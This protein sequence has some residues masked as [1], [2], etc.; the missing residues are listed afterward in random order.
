MLPLQFALVLL[1]FL[2]AAIVVWRYREQII[3][4]VHL[5]N[6]K[7]AADR[8]YSS[9]HGITKNIAYGN[10]ERE[11]LDI[12]QP[13]GNGPMPV[14][15]WVHG[16]SWTSGDKELYA[17]VAQRFMPENFVVV[18]PNYTIELPSAP[19]G[20]PL[21]FQQFREIAQAFVWTREN[22]SQFKGDPN[23]IVL[24]GHS[25]GAHLT[26]MVMLDPQYLAA[27]NHSAH[28]ICGWYGFAGP[29]SIP[30]QLEYELNVHKNDAGLLFEVFGGKENFVCG[31]P[32]TFVRGDTP[33]VFM[34]H[35][36]ADETV[37]VAIGENFQNALQKASAPSTLSIYRGAGHAG[38]LFDALAQ[39]KPRLVQD[40]VTFAK[41]CPPVRNE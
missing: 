20:E 2:L 40:M 21:V 9:Y 28:E 17:T 10:A 33:P 23:R 15:I 11:K 19:G 22:I 14:V 34:I 7:L 26:A 16:G 24:G 4:T 8:F 41:S 37:P 6:A 5:A 36:D 31:S 32:Q 1:P 29:Y 30:A 13:D 35:G 38:L 3:Y 18:I 39:A 12:Y 25:A 27:L